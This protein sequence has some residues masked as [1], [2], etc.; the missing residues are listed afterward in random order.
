MHDTD[1]L[2]ETSTAAYAARISLPAFGWSQA[3]PATAHS[4]HTL[5]RLRLRRALTAA[6]FGLQ[7]LLLQ[8]QG[9]RG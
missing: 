3:P 2:L 1:P 9:S 7:R 6:Q 4:R 5:R 8:V